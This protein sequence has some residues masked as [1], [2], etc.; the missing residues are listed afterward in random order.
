M[1]AV[2]IPTLTKEEI[3]LLQVDAAQRLIGELSSLLPGINS[4]IH[5]F[6]IKK[7]QADIELEK[8]KHSKNT[9]IEMMRA[10]KV[11]VHGG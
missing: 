2:K 1:S 8:L 3:Q 10:L 7:G 9:I 6:I 4:D 11:V 5:Q